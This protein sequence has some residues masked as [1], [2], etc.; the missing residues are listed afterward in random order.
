MSIL[1]VILKGK[2][3]VLCDGLIKASKVILDGANRQ[4]RE[5]KEDEGS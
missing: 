4:V 5:L 3:N 1:P 2:E